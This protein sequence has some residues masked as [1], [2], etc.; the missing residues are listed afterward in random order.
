M[1]GR[2]SAS[3]PPDLTA[4]T[5]AA[6]VVDEPPPPSWNVAPTDPASVVV[7]RGEGR[8]LRTLRWGL[9][10]S[11]ADDRRIASRLINARA[12]TVAEKPAFRAALARRRCL[13]PAD[14]WYEWRAA[15]DRKKQPFFITARDGAPV[16][17]AGLYE[18]WRDPATEELVRTCAVVTTSA[19]PDLAYLHERMP[20]VLAPD[21]WDAWLDPAHDDTDA[22][23]GLLAP[24]D[25]FAAYPVS[26]AVNSVR[27]NGPSLVEP[28][29]AEGALF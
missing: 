14:G 16:A 26:P 4:E 6:A 1:C 5:Y 24:R 9:I 27:N 23:C 18:V 12:E 20:A 28:L 11:W 2:Y 25:G 8:E 21:V 22:L 10:P 17:F 15:A 7:E 3:R 13:V 29:P 19:A